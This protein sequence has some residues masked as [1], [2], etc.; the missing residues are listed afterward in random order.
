MNTLKW[1]LTLIACVIL[2]ACDDEHSYSAYHHDEPIL[3]EFNIVDSYGNDSADSHAQYFRINPYVNRGNYEVY[4]HVDSDSPYQVEFLLGDSAYIDDATLLYSETC[5]DGLGYG[6]GD[7]G[8][9]NCRFELDDSISCGDWFDTTY[10]GH[11]LY[12][13]PQP[14]YLFF[15]ICD[16]FGDYCEYDFVE[17][18]F[19]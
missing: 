3:Q 14:L 17:L 9:Q 12:F 11:Y 7:Y 5:G 15:Q 6:C 19:E 1:S 10:I 2:S 18:M 13:M 16:E 8:S 4:W